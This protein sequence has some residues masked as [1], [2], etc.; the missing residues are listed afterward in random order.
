LQNA[1]RSLFLF[2]EDDVQ[3]FLYNR[4]STSLSEVN[5]F[6]CE[7]EMNWALIFSPAVIWVLIPITAIICT[8]I[9]KLT[10]MYQ[11]H[12]ERIAMIERGIDP[13]E[14]R[15]GQAVCDP[16]MQKHRRSAEA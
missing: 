11:A 16:T 10:R 15:E 5:R 1:C 12:T 14:Y 6:D 8:T 3:E 7:V 9:V 2:F 4:E 13:G